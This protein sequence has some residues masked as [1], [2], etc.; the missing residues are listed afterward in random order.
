[1][2]LVETF[3]RDGL[4]ASRASWTSYRGG[5]AYNRLIPDAT[6]FLHRRELFQ[7]KHAVVAHARSSTSEKEAAYGQ[8]ARSWASVHRWGSGRVFQ[9]FADPDL[10]EWADAYYGTNLYRLARIKARNDE[11][12][13]FRSPSRC[14]C[15]RCRLRHLQI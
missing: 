12:G 11:V 13:L 4:Q 6:A 2:G 15:A 5:G 8:V 14:V 7:L 10:E 1:V 3:H 9:N